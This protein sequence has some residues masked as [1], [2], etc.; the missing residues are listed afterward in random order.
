MKSLLYYVRCAAPAADHRLTTW[1][2]FWRHLH[3]RS[4]T[5]MNL[6]WKFLFLCVHAGEALPVAIACCAIMQNVAKKRSKQL[7]APPIVSRLESKRRALKLPVFRY[8]DV[9]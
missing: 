9:L 7:F 3:G 6:F 2:Y 1:L 8:S 4:N 5:S